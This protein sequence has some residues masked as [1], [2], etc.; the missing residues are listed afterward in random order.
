MLEFTV[1]NWMGTTETQW[2]VYLLCTLW[3]HLWSSTLFY[4]TLRLFNIHPLPLKASY[5]T[6][7][8]V[9][10]VNIFLYVIVSPTGDATIG[11]TF[12]R[13]LHVHIDANHYDLSVM[14]T[15]FCSHYAYYTAWADHYANGVF[16][17][18]TKIHAVSSG[19][20][21]AVAA[22]QIISENQTCT[23]KSIEHTPS[24]SYSHFGISPI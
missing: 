5:L 3:H 21:Q 24:A 7:E 1:T 17:T 15:I 13:R 12:L 20:T 11:L 16:Q 10:I 23:V 22:N 6:W 18:R 8:N 14:I 19:S 2:L 9:V 4:C